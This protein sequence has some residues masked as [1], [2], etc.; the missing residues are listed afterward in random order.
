MSTPAAP[1]KP[2]FLSASRIDTFMTCS[3]VYAAKYLY[4]LPEKGND[5]SNRGTVCHE[6]LELLIKPRHKD[7]YDA[8][9][10]AGN[11]REVPALWRLITWKARHYGVGDPANLKLIDGFMMVG[12]S[13]GFFGPKGAA[14]H[15]E[16]EFSLQ[17]NEDGK[18]YNVRG[19]IDKVFEWIE[20]AVSY[21]EGMDFKSSKVKFDG[22][23]LEHN[24][25]SYIYQIAMRRLFPKAILRRF[26]FLFLK[27][28]KAPI[29]EQP[30]FTEDQISG[31]EYQLTAWQSAMESFTAANASDN[32]AAYDDDRK[33][34]CGREGTKKDGSVCWI[35]PS[36]KPLDYWVMLDAQGDFVRSAFTEGELIPKEGYVVVPRHYDGCPVYFNPKTGLRRNTA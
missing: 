10:S 33:W 24:T 26:H 20:K 2:L 14:V 15:A 25:Q 18:R 5:G 29:Q 8:A 30:I 31:F 36:R 7:V 17:V 16:R 3:Q 4:R 1:G 21:V 6:V 11:C 13:V 34:L 12:L 19:V 35:C 27:F 32:L 9:I 22:D 23:K 28:P